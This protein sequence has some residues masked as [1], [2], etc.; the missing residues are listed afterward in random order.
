MNG[1]TK[2]WCS[3][4]KKAKVNARKRIWKRA[5]TYCN[6]NDWIISFPRDIKCLLNVFV[7]FIKQYMNSNILHY[8][9]DSYSYIYVVF[10]FIPGKSSRW[11]PT[12]YFNMLMQNQSH[13]TYLNVLQS[14]VWCEVS[15]CIIKE[16]H[17]NKLKKTTTLYF[18]QLFWQLICHW[19]DQATTASLQKF[20]ISTCF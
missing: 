19:S 11:M 12:H 13:I 3:A 8:I 14:S 9:S 20:M 1:C 10:P 18:K 15:Q 16:A 17:V 2:W 5:I 7:V 6:T 4:N